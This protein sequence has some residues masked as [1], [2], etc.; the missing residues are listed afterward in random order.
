MTDP[1]HKTSDSEWTDWGWQMRNRVRSAAD[2]A[3]WIDP[4]EDET[5]AISA[6]ADRFRFV[7][8]PYYASLMRRDDPYHIATVFT[9]SSAEL[10]SSASPARSGRK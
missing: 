3:E 1:A 5:R 10:S 2:L 4:T 6:L 7:I 9:L 8:T